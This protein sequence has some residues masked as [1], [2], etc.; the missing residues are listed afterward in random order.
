MNAGAEPLEYLWQVETPPVE[1]PPAL[2]ALL[3]GK[4]KSAGPPAAQPRWVANAIRD[5]VAEGQKI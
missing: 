3:A 4:A 1:M 2:V 5:G